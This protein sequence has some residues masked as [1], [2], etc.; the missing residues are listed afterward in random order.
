[1]PMH[2]LEQLVTYI[3]KD[4]APRIIHFGEDFWLEDLPVGTRVI[5]PPP[6]L[7][8]L[9]NVDAAIRH[10]ITHP[11]GMEPL[12]ALLTPGMKVTIAVDDISLPLP[13]MKTPEV[14]ERILKVVLGMLAD[15][16]VDDVH[17]IVATGVHRRMTEAEIKRMV[18][19][20]IFRDFWPDR[21]Y[22]HDAEDPNG[23]AS[24]G[25]TEAGETVELNR[26]AVES[27][28]IIYVNINLV[29]MNGG[30]KSVGVGLCNYRTLLNHHNPKVLRATQTYMDPKHSHM[31]GIYERI[32]KH[33]NEHLKIFHIETVLNNRM[34]DSQLDFLAKNEDHFTDLDWLK[35]DGLRFSLKHLPRSAKNK[36]MM[37]VPAAYDVVQVTAGATEPVHEKTIEKCFQQYSVPVKGQCDVL[38]TGIP[39]VSPYNINS[40]LNPLL[41]QVMALGY[42]HNMNRG[43]PLLRKGGTLI[44]CHPCFDAFDPEHHPSYIEF[45]NRLLPETRDAM[46]LHK[47]YEREF[48]ENP[49]YV[50]RFRFGNAYHGA[51]PF[52]MWYWG[53][54]GRQWCGRVIA[55]GAENSRVPELMG[56]E[57]ADSLAEAIA[58][59]RAT[60]PETPDITMVHHPPIFM[61][62]VTP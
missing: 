12:H 20:R 32:G 55:A 9:A 4:S 21:L 56:W 30:H 22:N 57:R 51:H 45:F 46:T 38:I 60:A 33:I 10:A 58:M 17:I 31:H 52:F 1:M 61:S 2:D 19:S 35:F 5:Y 16:G 47:K 13:P 29:P 28:L 37:K 34:Y 54:G 11:L 42:F 59:A 7:E 62:D 39:Y 43:T 41:V 36:I 27:D 49:S 6:P 24:L 48:A 14:R 8:G 18:G 26:R 25:K 40:I 15:Y 23:I 44:L 50:D 3:D 53:E